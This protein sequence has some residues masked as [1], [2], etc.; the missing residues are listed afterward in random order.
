MHRRASCCS[1][2]RVILP[3]ENLFDIVAC[4]TLPVSM[5]TGFYGMVR[6][7]AALMFIPRATC[8]CFLSFLTMGVLQNMVPFPG[9]GIDDDT[10]YEV[11]LC[12]PIVCAGIVLMM[13]TIAGMC[14]R[15]KMFSFLS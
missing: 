11:P 4:I 13:L 12:F 6:M 3:Q 8:E 5:V 1:L 10:G 14:H 15:L 2:R 9:L 7:C